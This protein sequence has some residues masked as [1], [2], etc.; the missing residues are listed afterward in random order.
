MS[1]ESRPCLHNQDALF[2][3]MHLST[4]RTVHG[5]CSHVTH[6]AERRQPTVL[7]RL[8]MSLQRV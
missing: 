7:E 6:V 8:Q 4:L 2:H 1:I 3:V 5:D